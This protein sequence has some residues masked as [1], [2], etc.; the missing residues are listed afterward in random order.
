MRTLVDSNLR[1]GPGLEHDVAEVVPADTL[2]T[3]VALTPSAD[4]LELARGSWIWA[5]LADTAPDTLPVNAGTQ[6]KI[7]PYVPPEGWTQPFFCASG[8]S[9]S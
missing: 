1:T 8:N 3:L 6:L 7:T 9:I 5:E 4:W 2:L